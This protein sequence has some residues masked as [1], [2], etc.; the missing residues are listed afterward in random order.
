MNGFDVTF[1]D[2]QDWVDFGRS[3]GAA[4]EQFMPH[5]PLASFFTIS[6]RVG[7]A[8]AYNTL[9]SVMSSIAGWTKGLCIRRHID[10]RS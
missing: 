7:S 8:S 4:A 6:S 1:R 10:T 2:D 3:T 5:L 9:S